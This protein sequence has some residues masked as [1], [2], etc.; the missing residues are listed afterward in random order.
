MAE[1]VLGQR[2]KPLRF[3]RRAPDLSSGEYLGEVAEQASGAARLL[4]NKK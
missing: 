4:K 1:A 3:G 2:L